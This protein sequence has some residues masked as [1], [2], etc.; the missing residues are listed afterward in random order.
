MAIN[1]NELFAGIQSSIKEEK[2][3]EAQPRYYDRIIKLVMPKSGQNEYLFRLLPYIKE[4][5]EGLKKTFFFYVK[6]FWQDDLGS[7]HSVLSRRT[8]NEPCMI[9][10]Y[11]YNT[12]KNGSQYDKEMVERRLKYK[13]GWY[14][15]VLV[16]NDPVNPNN[17]GKVMVLSLNKT[18]WLKVQGALNGELDREW[19]ARANDTLRAVNPNSTQEI[20][21]NVGQLVTDLTDKGVNLCVKIRSKGGFPDYSSSEFTRQDAKLGFSDERQQEV[22]DQCIDVTKLEREVS[23]E[24]IAK[25]F[26]ETFLNQ[27]TDITQK[28]EKKAEPE[29]DEKNPFGEDDF[30]PGIEETKRTA[31]TAAVADETEKSM[32]DFINDLS[33]N[34]GYDFN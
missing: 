15:N 28:F 30:I 17:N 6:Y 14:C 31:K 8:F 18:L 16:V 34:N 9:A 33:N 3:T 32:D 19:S 13:Q 21:I 20:H 1:Y 23:A 12:K 25:V 11:Y 2:K 22:L 24:D 27:P 5:K 26:R 29:V 4:G 7:Y 10:S